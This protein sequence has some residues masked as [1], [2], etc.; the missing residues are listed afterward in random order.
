[1]RKVYHKIFKNLFQ[2]ASFASLFAAA[3][4]PCEEII[5]DNVYLHIEKIS[6][7]QFHECVDVSHIVCDNFTLI[8]KLSEKMPQRHDRLSSFCL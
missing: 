7:K 4:V 8:H 5:Y 6:S 1:M 3:A 2:V